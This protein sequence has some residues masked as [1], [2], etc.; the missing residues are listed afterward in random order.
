MASD[1]WQP[2]PEA[3]GREAKEYAKAMWP[4]CDWNALPSWEQHEAH[5]AAL[6]ALTR[7]HEREAMMRDYFSHIMRCQKC[8]VCSEVAR[9]AIAALDAEAV[10]AVLGAGMSFASTGDAVEF[11]GVKKAALVKKMRGG[12]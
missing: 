5:R 8:A 4:A 6:R 7:Q 1:R 11:C 12:K 3:L 10:E 9:A 2:T